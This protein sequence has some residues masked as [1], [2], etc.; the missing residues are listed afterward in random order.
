MYLKQLAQCSASERMIIPL[1]AKKALHRVRRVPSTW[2]R[3][4]E[5][6]GSEGSRSP[7]DGMAQPGF[8][9][10]WTPAPVLCLMLFLQ[11]VLPFPI[12]SAWGMPPYLS[13]PSANV[14]SSR[15]PSLTSPA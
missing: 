9:N 14:T 13:E 6:T 15:K 8:R 7:S 1:G 4:E 2:P 11:S 3:A 12:L 10:R 5:E